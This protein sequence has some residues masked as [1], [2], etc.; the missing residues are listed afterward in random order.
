MN[1]ILRLVEDEI[2]RLK[3][4]VKEYR[5]VLNLLQKDIQNYKEENHRLR[6]DLLE[7]SKQEYNKNNG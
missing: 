7:L 6:V 2:T 5:K 1:N 4:Q 3:E